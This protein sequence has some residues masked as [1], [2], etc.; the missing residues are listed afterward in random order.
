VKYEPLLQ[1]IKEFV[2]AFFK[3]HHDDR[4]SYHN[5][6]HTQDVVSATIKIAN[7]YQ[8]SD[9]DFFAVC[10][11]AWFHDTGYVI[12]PHGHEDKSVEVAGNFLK[13]HEVSPEVLK[14]IDGCIYAT[15]IPQQ[16]NNLLENVICDADLFNLGTDKFTINGKLLRKEAAALS[17][18]ATDKDQWRQNNINFLQKHQYHTDYCRLL[19]NDKKEEN[20]QQLIK[21][22][23]RVAEAN[24]E[25]ETAKPKDA[26][27]AKPADEPELKKGSV[28][29][30]KG[31]ETMLRITSSN[32]QHLSNMA[33]S[34]AHIMI[35]V[36][37]IIIS[38]LLSL[39]LRKVDEH[40]KQVIPAILLLIV[41]L[42]TIVFSILAT[43]P[44][45]T[46][47]TFTQEDIDN[48]NVNLLFFGNY[49][50]MTMDK[51][52]EGMFDMMNDS[53]FLYASIIRDVYAQGV[54][55]GRKYH[56]L[57]ISYSVFM[58]GLIISVIAFVIS[59]L[60]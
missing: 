4:L 40:P 16:P 7:H 28:K 38:L 48:R 56:L 42:T 27:V 24:K 34:K 58:Y 15:K 32:Q 21:K 19:L 33:D 22:Q 55:L 52:R 57:R 43:R 18:V 47:G 9:E 26:A 25:S 8:L 35:S 49:Y 29:Q 54:V 13:E 53:E 2:S 45:I 60:V 37:S 59:S 50:K 51:Y 1:L 10:A 17:G 12:D 11:A 46:Q 39:L 41:N 5:I 3:T 20:L 23:N 14:K 6:G 44:N 36:N 30:G 31:V